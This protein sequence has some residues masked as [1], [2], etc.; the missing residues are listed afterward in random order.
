MSDKNSDTR[1]A[2]SE[3]ARKEREHI[4]QTGGKDPGQEK[5]ERPFRD[6]YERHEKKKEQSKRR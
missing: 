4:V 5:A 1:T 3:A 2:I 6:S